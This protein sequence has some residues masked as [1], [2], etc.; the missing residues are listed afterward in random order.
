MSDDEIAAALSSGAKPAEFQR[1][2]EQLTRR[3][4]SD[5]GAAKRF[6]P[7]LIELSR[8]EALPDP[9]L[10]L[11]VVWA[12]QYD[13]TESP[14]LRE[15]LAAALADRHPL[16]RF[17]AATSL[18][19]HRDGRA[20]VVL[21]EML[22]PYP[23]T[24]PVAGRVTQLLEGGRKPDVGRRLARIEREGGPAEDVAA[25]FDAQVGQVFVSVDREVA[26][27]ER[28]MNL[29][30]RSLQAQNAL[31]ALYLVGTE[32]ELPVIDRYAAGAIEGLSDTVAE[33]ARA[34]AARIR[35]E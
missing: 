23:V 20:R 35:D 1:A 9:Q 18:A 28:L 33:Q 25:P 31:A 32:A 34:T 3:M 22:A 8:E 24:A 4:T 6:H 27:G 15:A 5:P 21:L 7:A 17:N 14:E 29:L 2:I 13:R 19:R 16:V 12:M 30:P 26:E 10:R 11:L